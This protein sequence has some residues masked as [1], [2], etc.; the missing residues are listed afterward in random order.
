MLSN[1]LLSLHWLDTR[2]VW[3]K[4]VVAGGGAG[5]GGG[6][7]GGGGG[8]DW[9]SNVCWPSYHACIVITNTSVKQVNNGDIY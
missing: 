3:Q 5:D 7:A 9:N 1:S 2:F 6:G 8:R 4:L